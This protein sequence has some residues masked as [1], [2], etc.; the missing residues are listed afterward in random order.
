MQRNQLCKL[1]FA[2]ISSSYQNVKQFLE[3]KKKKKKKNNNNKNNKNKNKNKKK[4]KAAEK[5]KK[6]EKK[7]K[8]RKMIKMIFQFSRNEKPG[9]YFFIFYLA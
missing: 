2:S 6:K 4:K 5:L 3:K 8:K 7:K 9:L 1:G